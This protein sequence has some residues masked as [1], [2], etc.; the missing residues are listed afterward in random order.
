MATHKK[1]SEMSYYPFYWL[2][3]AKLKKAMMMDDIELGVL[4]FHENVN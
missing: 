1:R 4:L 3:H 2:V